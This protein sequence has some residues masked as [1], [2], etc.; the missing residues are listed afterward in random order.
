VPDLPALIARNPRRQA[1]DVPDPGRHPEG[2]TPFR[3]S[4]RAGEP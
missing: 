2:F 4:V 1:S 3:D